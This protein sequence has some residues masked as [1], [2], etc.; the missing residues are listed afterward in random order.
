MCIRTRVCD[1]T[2]PYLMLLNPA[3]M[4][5]CR[6]ATTPVYT[7]KKKLDTMLAT[8]IPM[9]MTGTSSTS[10]KYSGM[11]HQLCHTKPTSQGIHQSR[12]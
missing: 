8:T 2:T 11:R 7:P 10:S 9:A 1:A 5:W 4:E 3:T 6:T 12:V